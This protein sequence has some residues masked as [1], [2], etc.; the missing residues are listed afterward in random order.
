MPTSTAVGCP[1]KVGKMTDKKQTKKT[2]TLPTI[3][4]GNATLTQEDIFWAVGQRSGT[5][6]SRLL[7]A[8]NFKQFIET[9]DDILPYWEKVETKAIIDE[10][11]GLRSHC[12]CML[13][14]IRSAIAEQSS[15]A[16]IELP[17]LPSDYH[18]LKHWMATVKVRAKQDHAEESVQPNNDYREINYT[19]R[20]VTIGVMSYPISSIKAWA[21]LVELKD[22]RRQ[23]E[24]VSSKDYKSAIDLLR[25]QLKGKENL[26]KIIQY[27]K[28]GYALHPEVKITNTSQVGI[29][30]TR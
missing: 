8:A 27:V 12:E 19:D 16:D 29:R 18:E 2:K 3:L 1:E 17:P 23:R 30:R 5:D 6:Y 25:R 22:A 13:L 26:R 4:T 20:T 7:S 28:G 21:V 10:Q 15:K 9:L 11:P 24:A 14:M